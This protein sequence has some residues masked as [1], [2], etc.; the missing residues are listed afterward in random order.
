[1]GVDRVFCCVVVL[2]FFF[3]AE[4]AD[5]DQIACAS[6]DGLKAIRVAH[7]TEDLGS[8]TADAILGGDILESYRFDDG[9]TMS[10]PAQYPS[11][12]FQIDFPPEGFE[13]LCLRYNREGDP[14]LIV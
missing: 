6:C 14:R 3:A 9:E 2:V 4:K 5:A 13:H 1:M 10:L 11:E 12:S 8:Y 7:D